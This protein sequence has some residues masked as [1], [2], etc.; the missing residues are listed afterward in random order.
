MVEGR[1]SDDYR[2]ETDIISMC[3]CVSVF[4]FTTISISISLFCMRCEM[5][6]YYDCSVIY[7]PDTVVLYFALVWYFLSNSLSMLSDQLK[8]HRLL[9]S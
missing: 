6:L 8:S 4:A 2:G 7:W 5:F 1:S 9:V 3:V